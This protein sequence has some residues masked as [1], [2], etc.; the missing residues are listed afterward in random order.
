MAVNKCP[1]CGNMLPAG[2]AYC[3]KCG[4]SLLAG[5]RKCPECHRFIPAK[6]VFCP[7][8]GKMV[9]NDFAPE[10]S[11][12]TSDTNDVKAVDN[13]PTV[14]PEDEKRPKEEIKPTVNISR[15]DV[16]DRKKT[17]RDNSRKNK[18]IS[19]L[20]VLV[21]VVLVV[22]VYDWN[23]GNILHG[24]LQEQAATTEN[25][26]PRQMEN[27]P[28]DM[29]DAASTYREVAM[30]GSRSDEGSRF[31]FAAYSDLRGKERIVGV[32]FNSGEKQRSHY[33][34]MELV[35]LNGEWQSLGEVVKYIDNGLL[36]FDR[37]SLGLANENIPRM[38]E[39]DGKL[40]FY[41]V[42]LVMPSKDAT[43]ADFHLMPSLFNVETKDVIQADFV[44]R[45]VNRGGLQMYRGKLAD[46]RETPEFK[47]LSRE[48]ARYSI[49][50]SPTAEE[51]ELEAPENAVKKWTM[52]NE[53]ALQ[54][55]S[56]ADTT[57]TTFVVMRYGSPLFSREEVETE[58]LVERGNY[59][60]Y[61]THA[62]AVYG[63]DRSSHEFF[64]AYVD[65]AGNKPVIDITDEGMLHV[66]AG[67]MDFDFDPVSCKVVKN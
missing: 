30:Q 63:Y 10:P 52:D 62:G 47:F 1:K 35:S 6:S 34:I 7:L 32:D 24:V 21:I 50:Y 13:K 2:A 9:R 54:E 4:A 26:K 5:M 66:V 20:L 22:A 49:I 59:L 56:N 61:E 58:S 57:T 31:A 12:P 25:D 67:E 64:I 45:P 37:D 44:C 51:I 65:T 16:A 3:G 17:A 27:L 46:N 43:D 14:K 60:F 55:L 29:E 15:D 23:G 40:Y 41:F 38:M 28:M 18:L 36:V 42:Y 53:K 11:V 19:I 8:C 33:R 39:L 48:L